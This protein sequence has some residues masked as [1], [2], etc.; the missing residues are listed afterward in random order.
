[1]QEL[2]TP[3]PHCVTTRAAM[4][5]STST[6]YTCTQQRR[7]CSH[8]VT[9]T[10]QPLGHFSAQE[11][12]QQQ[13]NVCWGRDIVHRDA[14]LCAEAAARVICLQWC[15]QRP[16]AAA[17]RIAYG[18]FVRCCSALQLLLHGLPLRRFC[19]VVACP[20]QQQQQ[21]HVRGQWQLSCM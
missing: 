15:W 14:V 5:L 9:T 20:E 18:S 12:Q 8:A 7:R 10:E 3:T 17:Q 19:L 16:A 21:Q 6:R 1:V 11:Q 2:L 4:W 13:R